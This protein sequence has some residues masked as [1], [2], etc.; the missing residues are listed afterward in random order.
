VTISCFLRLALRSFITGRWA[1][2][3]YPVSEFDPDAVAQKMNQHVS[4]TDAAQDNVL[5][6]DE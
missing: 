6:G 4:D 3:T 5:F 2:Q 1:F